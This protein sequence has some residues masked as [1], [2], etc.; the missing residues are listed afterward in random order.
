[1]NI[2][3]RNEDTFGGKLAKLRISRHLTQADVATVANISTAYYSAIE[4]DKRIPPHMNILELILSALQCTKL[5]ETSLQELA[6]AER[7][8]TP[9]EL[10]LSDEAQALIIDIRE[11]GD[12]LTRRSIKAMRE[13][14][15]DVTN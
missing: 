13:Y 8:I 6:A 4:N 7:R 15:H 3:N 14:I 11:T 2:K 12:K 10:Y 1:M 5:E 9:M